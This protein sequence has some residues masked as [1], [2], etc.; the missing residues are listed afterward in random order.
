[1][2]VIFSQIFLQ[3][4]PFPSLKGIEF[5]LPVRE[6]ERSEAGEK[7]HPGS[8]RR[9]ALC[10]VCP[11]QHSPCSHRGTSCLSQVSR[12]ATKALGSHLL[13]EKQA[14]HND[15]QAAGQDLLP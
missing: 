5:L 2:K 10:L 9:G 15:G 13:G 7:G 11:G 6:K 3:P 14:P 1:M 12:V 4:T 8:L